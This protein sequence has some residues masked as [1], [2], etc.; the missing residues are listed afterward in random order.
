MSVPITSL[1]PSVGLSEATPAVPK[2]ESTLPVERNRATTSLPLSV[3]STV[4]RTRPLESTARALTAPAISN[5]G[6][7]GMGANPF[8]P[9]LRSSEQFSAIAAMPDNPT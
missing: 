8:A 7:E 2:L 5:A 4:A 1:V 6:T 9:K 3:F